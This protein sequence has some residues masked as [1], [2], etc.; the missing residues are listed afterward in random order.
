MI[1]RAAGARQALAMLLGGALGA[2]VVSLG[3]R[4]VDLRF[5]R[6]WLF[7][8]VPGAV[9][10][11]FVVGRRKVVVSEEAVSGP[12]RFGGTVRIT[13]DEL[14]LPTTRSPR[15]ITSRSG[16]VIYLAQ[17]RRRD[18]EAIWAALHSSE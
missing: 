14:I 10:I 16:Q 6:S 9:L 18:R 7:F 15:H 4:P 11:F 12:G 1:V 2:F 8:L 3:D 5:L 17:F 13:K